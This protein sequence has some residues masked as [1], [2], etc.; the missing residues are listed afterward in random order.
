M[1]RIGIGG[2]LGA[3]LAC[4]VSFLPGLP[5]TAKEPA[6]VP[7][8]R[9]KQHS[10]VRPKPPVVAAQGI[11]TP[12]PAPA[13][14]VVLF[15]G[16]SLAQWVTDTGEP[17]AWT[18]GDGFFEVTPNAG[19]ILT[20]ESFGDVQLHIEWASPSPAAGV[21]QDR[22]NSGVFLMGRYEIQILDTFQADTYADGQTGAVYGEAPPLFNASLPPGAWQA[23]DII[24]RG[25]QFSA[26]GTLL[27][28]AV[29]TVLH[30]GIAVQNNEQV[31]G[32]T[33]WLNTLAYQS[34]PREAPI[35]LQDHG[36]A[37]RFRNIWARRL[38]ARLE[39]SAE[40]SRP[41]RAI[42]KTPAELAA[43][44]G[45]FQLG[46]DTTKP[47]VAMSVDGN[48]LIVRFPDRP[49]DMPIVPVSEKVFEF[50][51][52]DATIEFKTDAAGKPSDAPMHIGGS[53]RSLKRLK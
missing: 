49:V 36:Q 40:Q 47:P 35:R 41:P 13:D 52:T 8:G 16:D 29:V 37:V 3:F 6:Q 17:A 44:A 20:R 11:A 1:T 4:G 27:A 39:P 50:V 48:G 24:F 42:A 34:H 38:P 32:P 15:G 25:P 14:A 5:A 7:R 23:F 2:L 30:N 26:D 45:T 12:R 46:D 19:A 31:V 22:G 10:M 33:S 43:F 9:W 21:G 53:T 28:P 51:N 18:V